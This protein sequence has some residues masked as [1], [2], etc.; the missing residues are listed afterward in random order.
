MTPGTLPNIALIGRMGAGKTSIAEELMGLY[1]YTK[2]SWATPVKTIGALAYGT[3]AKDV[4]YEVAVKGH[5]EIRTGRELLQRIGTDAMREQVDENFW[6]RVGVRHLE[7]N[8]GPFVNDDTRFPNEADALA[9]R[10]WI[11]VSVSLPEKERLQRL[12]LIYG[13]T[14]TADLLNHPS[15]QHVDKIKANYR[16]WNTASPRQVAETLM[17]TLAQHGV[18]Q[19]PQR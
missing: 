11:I 7:N 10:E 5:P 12:H 4:P 9:R 14:L 19:V 6:I 1:G 2:F 3:I 17:H 18:A 15:E 13:D 16:L 8:P